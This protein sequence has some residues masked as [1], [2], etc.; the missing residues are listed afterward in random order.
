[1][2]AG[3][4]AAM[5]G[6]QQFMEQRMARRRENEAK[7][8]SLR[9][10]IAERNILAGHSA[11]EARIEGLR[12]ARSEAAERRELFVDYSMVRMEQDKARRKQITL[13]EDQLADELARRKADQIREE[14]E[15]RRICDGSEELRRLKERLHMAKVNKERA[16]QLL[17][18]EVRKEKDRF[19]DQKL[20]ESM[21]NERLEQNELEIKLSVEKAKQAER[22]KVI[23]QQQ[24]AMKEA[25]K[26]E[27]LEEYLKE[28]QQVENLVKKIE[29]EDELERQAREEKKKESRE[30]LRQFMIEQKEKQQQM[31][32]QEKAENEEIERFA[33][34][35][36]EH[37]ERLA[38]EQEEKEREKV[39]LMN[40]MV[41]QME[42]KSKEKEELEYLRNEL[43]AEELEAQSRRQEEMR[44]RK[45]LEDREEMKQAYLFQM[46]AKEEKALNARKEEEKIRAE[47]MRK[48]A[49]DDRLEQLNDHKRRMKYE[50]H[51]READRLVQVRREMYDLA[52]QKEMEEVEWLKKD[53]GQRQAII[54]EERMR[55]LKEHAQELKKFLPKHTLENMEDYKLLFGD[56]AAAQ[57]VAAAGG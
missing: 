48:F 9:R 51:K 47:A 21:E 40:K 55:L 11:S 23:N 10:S 2:I 35:K 46:R 29:Q 41:G 37:E 7:T 43:H 14:M 31:E 45:K 15:K 13:F 57:M 52:R 20:D 53:E 34:L 44:V 39:R 33:R 4:R 26:Q 19:I 42:A 18:I 17:E 56:D 6:T 38:A 30:M 3:S 22:V 28:R 8:L 36:R 27:A 25:A 54:E 1:V 49:E 16:V 32:A 50:Q 24:I 5:S 12:R